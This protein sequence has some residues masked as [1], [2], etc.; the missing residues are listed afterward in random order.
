MMHCNGCA[1]VLLQEFTYSGRTIIQRCPS[2]Q[3]N[4]ENA[5]HVARGYCLRLKLVGFRTQA[6][7]L[8][9]ITHRDR[10]FPHRN[11]MAPPELPADAPVA[12]LCEPIE[13]RIGVTLR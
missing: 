3:A 2:C 6:R 1:V 12:F 7:K 10:D 8:R 4:F 9:V 13:I 11:A 5:I